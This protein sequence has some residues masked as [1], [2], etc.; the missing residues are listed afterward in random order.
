MTRDDRRRSRGLPVP[1][2]PAER[3][4]Q[5]SALGQRAPQPAVVGNVRTGTAGWTD[6]SLVKSGLFYPRGASDARSRLSYYAEHFGLVEVD[7]TYYS[8]LPAENAVRW[9]SSTPDS[10]RFSVKAFP[11]LTGHPFDIDRLPHALRAEL[12]S[13]GYTGRIRPDGLPGDWARRLE[14][15]FFTMLEPLERAGKLA[16]VLLQFPPWFGA[17]RGNARKIE[18]TRE[19]WP[20]VPFAVEFRHPSWLESGRC[21][22]V[23]DLLRRHRM[24][25]VCVDE[26][27]GEIGGVPAVIEVTDPRLAVVRLHGQN[28]SGWRRGA[29][30]QERF[31]YL[32]GEDELQRWVGSVAELQRSAEQVHVV[33]NNC[34]RDYAVLNAKGFAALLVDRVG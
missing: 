28:R 7:A 12:M 19:R 3:V 9:A 27:E 21:D 4:L 32:Y 24:S 1:E 22:R 17:T 31:N 16:S 5:A 6:P 23:F 10:F 20:E 25:Y 2:V 14:K 26:P 29:S 33:F 8:L 30:V 18:L 34:V 11:I 15:E 13:A